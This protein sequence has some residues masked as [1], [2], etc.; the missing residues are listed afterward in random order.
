MIFFPISEIFVY[1]KATNSCEVIL[2]PATLLK[3]FISCWCFLM[4]FLGLH[5]LISPANYDFLISPFLIC[6]S[7]ISFRR[8]I[9]LAKTSGAVQ[10]GYGGVDSLVLFLILVELP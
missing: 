3:I 7:L 1:R 10:N 6:I 5:T 4:E 2:Y 8:L 9:A